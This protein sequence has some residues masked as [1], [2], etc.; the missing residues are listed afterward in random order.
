L[1]RALTPR[2]SE[3]GASR[4]RRSGVVARGCTRWGAGAWMSNLRACDSLEFPAT[5]APP[6][7]RA[8]GDRGSVGWRPRLCTD[9]PTGMACS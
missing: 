4:N 3:N 9:A 1:A 2:A 5:V 6:G 7:L 8:T